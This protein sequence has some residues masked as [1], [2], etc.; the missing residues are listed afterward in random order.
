MPGQSEIMKL[1]L[2]QGLWA[3]LFVALLFWTLRQNAK[4]EEKYLQTISENQTIIKN[5]SEN[6]SVIP[7]IQEDIKDIK[8]TLD[9]RGGRKRA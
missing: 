1:A 6:Y 4:R 7:D 5:L 9:I 8:D 3:A 2:S